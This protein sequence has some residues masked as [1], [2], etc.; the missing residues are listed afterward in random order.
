MTKDFNVNSTVVIRRAED[1]ADIILKPPESPPRPQENL[2]LTDQ[3]I[4]LLILVFSS[5]GLL[6][7]SMRGSQ[8]HCHLSI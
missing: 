4:A 8:T 7:V 6:D 2:K 5:A 3:Y 1:A